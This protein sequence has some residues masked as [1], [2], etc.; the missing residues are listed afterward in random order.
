MATGKGEGYVWVRFSRWTFYSCYFSPNREID[1]YKRFLQDIEVSVRKQG[2]MTVVAGD[3]NAKAP[4]WGSPRANA[5][6]EILTEWAARLDLVLS[7]VGEVPTFCRGPSTSIID[8]TWSTPPMAPLIKKWRVMEEETL[9]PHN[10]VH[11]RIQEEREAPQKW[12]GGK[13]WA[14]R[15]LEHEKL[16]K[17]LKEQLSKLADS[18]SPEQ[19]QTVMVRA[20]SDSMKRAG[21]A[22]GRAAYWWNAE[23]ADLRTAALRARR[24]FQRKRRRTEE[25]DCAGERQEMREAKKALRAAIHK[26][27]R[28]SWKKLCEE[29][30][31]NTWGEGYKIATRKIKGK[32]QIPAM[33]KERVQLVVE[34]LFHN[35]QAVNWIQEDC[36][37]EMTKDVTEAEVLIAAERL[38]SGKA[39]GPDGV[40]AE[41]VKALAKEHTELVRGMFDDLLKKGEFPAVWKTA[42]LVLLRKGDKPVDQPSSYRPLCLLDAAGKMLEQIVLRRL[43]EE[44]ERTGGLSEHQHGFREG[45]STVGA[46]QEVIAIATA[47]R[48]GTHRTRRICAMVTLDVRNAFNSAPWRRIGEEMRR[49]GVSA[50]LRRIVGSYLTDRWII[51]QN[52]EGRERMRVTCGV[53]QGSVLGPTLWNVLYDGVLR[54]EMPEGVTLIAYADDLALV[55]VAK[56][57]EEVKEKIETSIW[58][59]NEWMEQEGLKIAPEKTEAILLIGRRRMDPLELDVMG[60]RIETTSTIKYLGVT[61]DRGM[62]FA[63]HVKEVAARAAK[64]ASALARLMPNKGGPRSSKRRIL[65]SVTHSI[66]LYASPVLRQPMKKARIRQYYAQVQRRMAVRI[67]SAYRT[68]STEAALVIAG[69]PPI[70]LLVAERANILEMGGAKCSGQARKTERESLMEAWQNRW[71]EGT[72]GSWTRTLIADLQ[73]WVKRTHGELSFHLTQAMTGHGSFGAYLHKIG[74]AESSACVDCATAEDTAQHTIFECERWREQRGELKEKVGRRVTPDNI[75]GM[76]LEKEENWLAITQYVSGVISVKEEEERNRQAANG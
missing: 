27:Q 41:V 75:V 45:R 9:S 73:P 48:E 50:H 74:K 40:P 1:E 66:M 24:R 71:R 2:G 21:A 11:F 23:I 49:R 20:C 17:S 55:A 29:I 47:A 7:N 42:R 18:I 35:H 54:L 72:K 19:L 56:W 58:R 65:G 53:P 60:A 68:V 34:N 5:R 59:V 62:T 67:C 10:Y 4:D 46:I 61:L 25:E 32:G 69:I 14:I 12:T 39:P 3:F 37:E 22:R 26:S 51:T 63:P 30:D 76:M 36:S 52:E 70:D 33:S 15:T 28:E 43:T 8:L 13:R 57:K 16:T 44:I 6:G 38:N 31:H 64:T